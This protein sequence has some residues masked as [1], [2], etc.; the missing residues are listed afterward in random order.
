MRADGY[1]DSVMQDVCVVRYFTY[2]EN[3][4]NGRVD[5]LLN[6]VEEASSVKM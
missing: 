2:N 1:L 6:L 5:A 4:K 3:T